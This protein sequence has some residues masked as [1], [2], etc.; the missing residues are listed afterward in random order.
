MCGIAGYIGKRFIEKKIIDNLFV[1]MNNRGPDFKDY[2]QFISKSSENIN[3]FHSR[4]SI[5]D[6]NKRSNQPFVFKNYVLIFNGEIYN[7][8][9]IKKKL[10]KK[11]GAKFSTQSDTEV[12]IQAYHYLGI[13]FLDLL[14]GMWSFAI[15]DKK[16][17]K[18]ILSRDRFGEKPL[19]YVKTSDGFYFGSE[20]NYL[21]ILISD[22]LKVKISDVKNFL[23]LGYKAIDKFDLTFFEKL[24]KVKPS[25]YLTLEKNVL[26][27]KKYW[28]LKYNPNF[29]ISDKEIIDTFSN[30][31]DLSIEKQLRADVET[32]FYLSGG[33]D[34]NSICSSSS[35]LLNRKFK[36]FSIVDSD[37]R[38]NEKKRIYLAN[39]QL[40][41]KNF[42]LAI[43]KLSSENNLEKL[44]DIVS[45]HGKPVITISSVIQNLLNE[46]IKKNNIKVCIGGIGADEFLTGY[47][48][49]H[50]FYLKQINKTP[51][52][53][54]SL[55]NWNKFI[56][57]FVRNPYLKEKNYILKN[58]NFRSHILETNK[59]IY[60]YFY[61]KS[62]INTFKE[63]HYSNDVLRNRMLNEIFHETL[64]VLLDQED[65]N[66]MHHSIENRSPFL[67]RK[68]T[69]FIFTI[70]TPSLIKNGYTKYILRK[71]MEGKVDKRILYNRRKMGFNA[72]L[73]SLISIKNSNLKNFVL[74]KKSPIYDLVDIEK[75][76]GLFSKRNL[77]NS[78]SKFLFSLISC[79]IFLEQNL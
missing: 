35:K 47:Y 6:L 66:C 23:S 30:K 74:E 76:K 58:K 13:K 50:L 70:P 36:T 73:N 77:K 19:Y 18:L 2:K 56:K 14:E 29:K 55:K 63:T 60:R 48:D 4:L 39:Q 25:N 79:K 10:K 52:Y 64:P 71:S 42:S 3:L 53:L 78:E 68:L 51:K 69:E 21:K 45:Y 20:I 5:I 16:L 32:A 49:H 26:S 37:I 43:N 75:I 15:Y 7:H 24:K 1:S 9:E 61:N 12:L 62:H 11:Y 72:A 59:D 27:K 17:C 33:V 40:K 38:Y 46:S 34:S 67:D 54:E 8:I 44:K 28:N 22:N 41:S 57:G 65:L 31:F